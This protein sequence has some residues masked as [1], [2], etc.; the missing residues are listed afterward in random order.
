[1]SYKI[2]H[3]REL[4]SYAEVAANR[5]PTW[6]EVHPAYHNHPAD[7][8]NYKDSAGIDSSSEHWIQA[9][10]IQLLTHHVTESQPPINDDEYIDITDEYLEEVAQQIIAIQRQMAE[11]KAEYEAEE[12]SDEAVILSNPDNTPLIHYY[13]P[14]VAIDSAASNCQVF[15]AQDRLSPTTTDPT[16]KILIPK[17]S[18]S[19]TS[20]S[21][22]S[23]F[24]TWP[25]NTT[26]SCGKALCL[27]LLIC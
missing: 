26:S 22:L 21:N 3:E 14:N 2:E 7:D 23:N 16:A 8:S 27:P 6:D 10:P 15:L 18:I 19:L 9:R 5:T 11:W 4:E 17:L 25:N 1:M 12:V 24:T 13:P 20:T